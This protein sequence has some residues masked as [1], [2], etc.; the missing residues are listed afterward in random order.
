M[1]KGGGQAIDI[2]KAIITNDSMLI[3]NGDIKSHQRLGTHPFITYISQD[4]CQEGCSGFADIEL[5]ILLV[6]MVQMVSYGRD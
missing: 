2:V 4:D 3:G 6:G 5:L 1:T